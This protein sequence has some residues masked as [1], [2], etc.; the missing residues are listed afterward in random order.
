ME[1]KIKS[2]IK[3]FLKE[4]RGDIGI[5]QIAITV[6]VIVVIGA[7]MTII[8]GT[9]LQTWIGDVWDMFIDQIKDLMS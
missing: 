8:K 4:E 7:A 1:R 2:K 6:A 5:K 3:R 9:F